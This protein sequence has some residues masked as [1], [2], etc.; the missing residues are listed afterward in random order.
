M[1]DLS[2]DFYRLFFVT[3]VLRMLVI[4]DVINNNGKYHKENNSVNGT[5]VEQSQM[6]D[7]QSGLL[8]VVV[9]S[10]FCRRT[11]HP[12]NGGAEIKDVLSSS[13]MGSGLPLC[14]F[15]GMTF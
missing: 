13:C 3:S 9:Q 15:W 5:T 8:H 14:V 6:N 1:Q 12:G 11:P 2:I 4:Y 7:R 10:G